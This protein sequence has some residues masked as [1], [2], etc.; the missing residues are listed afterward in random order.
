MFSNIFYPHQNNFK[1][2][3]SLQR[4]SANTALVDG[5]SGRS[6]S[7]GEVRNLSRRLASGLL[8]L[9][10]EPGQ[11]IVITTIIIITTITITTRLSADKV[12][13]KV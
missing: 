2:C 5:V 10:T 6:Y 13:P 1:L 11:V 8:R 12:K 7:L 4:L 3:F 9:G